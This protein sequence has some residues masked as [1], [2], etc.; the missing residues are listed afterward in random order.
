MSESPSNS[1]GRDGAL[2]NSGV[3]SGDARRYGKKRSAENCNEVL[4]DATK[5]AYANL[6]NNPGLQAAWSGEI[7][8]T[9][10]TAQTISGRALLLEVTNLKDQG[11]STE[12]IIRFINQH[13]LTG[14]LSS[15]ELVEWKAAGLSEAVIQAALERSP[16][17]EMSVVVDD[18]LTT[19]CT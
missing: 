7:A 8:R 2:L 6:F 3:A 14:P 16:A 4:S 18:R 17:S 13:V 5:E 19:A 11:F 10:T 15:Q 9:G 1:K 12:L